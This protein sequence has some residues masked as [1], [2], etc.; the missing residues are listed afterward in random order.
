MARRIGG[1]GRARKTL[2]AFGFA[3]AAAC[4]LAAESARGSSLTLALLFGLAGLFNDFALPFSWASCSDV[5]GD[6][7]GPFLAP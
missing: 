1:M 2:A 5:G 6:S 3:A 4:L 7:R